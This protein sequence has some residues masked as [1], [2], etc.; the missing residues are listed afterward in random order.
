MQVRMEGIQMTTGLKMIKKVSVFILGSLILSLSTSILLS[1]VLGS[2]LNQLS[3]TEMKKLITNPFYEISQTS[4]KIYF[5]AYILFSQLPDK[6]KKA[7]FIL[8][9]IY[10]VIFYLFCFLVYLWI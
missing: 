10:F 2:F 6:V 1:D 8:R 5:I 7:K 9:G 3:E 4:F